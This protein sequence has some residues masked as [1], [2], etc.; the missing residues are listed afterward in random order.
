[1]GGPQQQPIQQHSAQPT[2]QKKSH[3]IAIVFGIIGGLLLLFIGSC[4]ICLSAA[5]PK[6][7]PTTTPSSVSPT[8]SWVEVIRWEGEAIKNTETF[9]ITTT[10]WRIRWSTRPGKFGDMNFQIY[11][12][13]ASGN[14][15]GVAANVIG[16]SS[17][18]SYFRGSG[19]YYLTIN[20][21]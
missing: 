17:D 10:E 7:Q 9:N 20:T 19:G 8:Q 13:S 6:S 3:A 2:S 12:Y 21:G 4:A 5:T 1:V 18:E 15:K 16:D 14:L 11:V